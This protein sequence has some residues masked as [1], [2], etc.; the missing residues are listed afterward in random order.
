MMLRIDLYLHEEIIKFQLLQ[1]TDRIAPW[2]LKVDFKQDL[3][4]FVFV[5]VKRGVCDKW[6]SIPDTHGSP[7]LCVFLSLQRARG[8]FFRL[9]MWC[10]APLNGHTP[11]LFEDLDC[12]ILPSTSNTAEHYGW[13]LTALLSTGCLS[14]IMSKKWW[15]LPAFF[16]LR[17]HLLTSLA[18]YV[19]C[20]WRSLMG[21]WKLLF[22]LSR[23]SMEWLFSH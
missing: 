10:N 22:L 7:W 1:A 4:T 16:K 17:W 5:W 18:R 9:H 20:G 21:R 12:L 8:S 15:S 23:H 13:L 14:L 3:T 19:F 11:V 6:F 2:E